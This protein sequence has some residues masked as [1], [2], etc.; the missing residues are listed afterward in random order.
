[1][2]RESDRNSRSAVSTLKQKNRLTP[3]HYKERINGG[4]NEFLGGV[5]IG[6]RPEFEVSGR[7]L[8]KT[9]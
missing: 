9:P 3:Q 6:V 1:M 8:K 7:T 4:G 2:L 5:L